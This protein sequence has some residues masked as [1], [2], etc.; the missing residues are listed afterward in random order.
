MIIMNDTLQ[1]I[2]T[3]WPIIFPAVIGLA[4]VLDAIFPQPVPGSFWYY[5][6][7]VIRVAAA[8]VGHAKNIKAT[9]APDGTTTTKGKT[10]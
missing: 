10:P 8:N 3:A 9:P 5:V 7:V 2:V 6:R 4:S 1:A